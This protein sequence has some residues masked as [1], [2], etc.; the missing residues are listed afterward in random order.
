MINYRHIQQLNPRGLLARPVSLYKIDFYNTN[1][2]G[3]KRIHN[4]LIYDIKRDGVVHGFAGWFN[5]RLSDRVFLS[6]SPMAE[7]THWMNNFFPIEKPTPVKKGDTIL[8][9]VTGNLLSKKIIWTWGVRIFKKLN[10]TKIKEYVQ[11][12]FWSTP[13]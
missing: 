13:I 10:R 1:D 11:S 5:A 3:T 9:K 7:S 12:T 2:E 4:I 6:N 8:V